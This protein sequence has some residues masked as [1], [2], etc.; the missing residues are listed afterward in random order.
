MTRTKVIS[1]SGNSLVPCECVVHYRPGNV[2]NHL[3]VPFR[4][5]SR[6]QLKSSGVATFSQPT[7]L[8]VTMQR[9]PED[10]H[11]MLYARLDADAVCS[12]TTSCKRLHCSLKRQL[13]SCSVLSLATVAPRPRELVRIAAVALA[14]TE[15]S[16]VRPFIMACPSTAPFDE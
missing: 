15:P 14:L 11:A 10:V 2:T 9:Q 8:Q 3:G 6:V 13:A 5:G 12:L 1:C 4:L 16:E 7:N